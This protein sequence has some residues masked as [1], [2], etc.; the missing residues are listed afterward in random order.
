MSVEEKQRRV[1]PTSLASEGGGAPEAV[2]APRGAPQP[3][4]MAHDPAM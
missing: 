1:I 3:P 2:V 4:P